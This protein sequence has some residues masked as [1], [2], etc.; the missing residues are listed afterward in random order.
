MTK[1]LKLDFVRASWTLF[2]C[3]IL[4]EETLSPSCKILISLRII[5]LSGKVICSMVD[6]T[7]SPSGEALDLSGGTSIKP[8]NKTCD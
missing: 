2:L 3:Q 8:S 4:P 1:S 7:I 6:E 5:C